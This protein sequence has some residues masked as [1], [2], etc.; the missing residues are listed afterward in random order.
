MSDKTVVLEMEFPVTNNFIKKF[1][2]TCCSWGQRKPPYDSDG[3][4]K[5]TLNYY[6][7]QLRLSG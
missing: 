6:K 2:I 4:V 5:G 1:S 7:V 3:N